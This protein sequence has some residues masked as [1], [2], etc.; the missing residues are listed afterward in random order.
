MEFSLIMFSQLLN[1]PI[2]RVAAGFPETESRI[3]DAAR[4]WVEFLAATKY[5]Y[6]RL[7]SLKEYKERSRQ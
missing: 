6:P 2:L 4:A 5:H 7:H 3:C 1:I